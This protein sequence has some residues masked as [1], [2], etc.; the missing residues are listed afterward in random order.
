MLLRPFLNDEAS[1][2][3]TSQEDPCADCSP[4]AWYRMSSWIG[5]HHGCRS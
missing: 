1:C 5:G 3:L 2:G 4:Y